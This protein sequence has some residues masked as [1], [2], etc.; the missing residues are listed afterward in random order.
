M[1]WERV[2]YPVS[3]GPHTFKWTYAKN[4]QN[5]AGLDAASIDQIVWPVADCAD[6]VIYVD[7]NATGEND[8]SSWADAYTEL[9][10]ALAQTLGG[11]DIWVANGTY[12]PDYDVMAQIHNGQREATF[13]LPNNIGIYGGF[14]GG[15]STIYSGGETARDQRDPQANETILTGDLW[16]DGD[17]N[18][19]SYHVVSARGVSPTSILDGFTITAGNAVNAP[20]PNYGGGGIFNEQNSRAN[21]TR[22]T[23]S[24]NLGG[25]RGG[26]ILND[27]SSPT[28]TDCVF[29]NNYADY[30]GAICNR[31][32]GSPSLTSS[33]K[34]NNC[35]F[36]DNTAMRGGA[37]FNEQNNSISMTGCL[38]LRN[39]VND[40]GGA[41]YNNGSATLTNCALVQNS[42]RYE[43]GGIYNEF[44][45]TLINSAVVGN[46]CDNAGAGLRPGSAGSQDIII[47][48]SIFWGNISFNQSDVEAAQIEHPSLSINHS[49]V[50]GWS[51]NFGGVGNI[52]DDPRF[53]AMTPTDLRLQLNSPCIDAGDNTVLTSDMTTDILGLA[54]RMDDPDTADTGNG[55]APLVDMG[56]HEYD[57]NGDYDGDLVLNQ[58]DNCPVTDN[59]DQADTDADDVGNVC[60]NCPDSGNPEQEDTDGDTWGDSCD[61]C[62]ELSSYVWSAQTNSEPP[63]R[64]GATTAYD[65]ARGVTVLFGGYKS[66]DW[67]N[68]TWESDGTGWTLR[69]PANIPS[70]RSNHAMV[71]DSAR[72]VVVLFGGK[73]A[74]GQSN[75][76]WEWDGTDW[77]LRTASVKPEARGFHAM[78]YDSAR[79]V[80]VL[81]GGMSGSSLNDTWEWDGTFWQQRT[82]AMLPSA[83][84]GHAMVYD[85]KHGV[86]VLF[87][88]PD[89][90]TWKWNGNN[91]IL[92]N[93]PFAPS[94]RIRHAMAY[95]QIRGTT[96]LFGGST[97]PQETWEWDGWNW[98][99]LDLSPTPPAGAPMAL[100]TMTYDIQNRMAVLFLTVNKLSTSSETWHYAINQDDADSDDIG[101]LCD[102][103]INDPNPD[104]ADEDGDGVGDECD[105]C[106]GTIPGFGVDADGCP[107][108]ITGDFNRDGDVDSG[109]FAQFQ[110]YATGPGLACDGDACTADFDADT[111]IDQD[112]FAIFQRCY[113]G[114]NIP[115]N[116]ADPACAN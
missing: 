85:R 107:A 3:A 37:I 62:P 94:A 1:D 33:P 6:P 34:L 87:G 115:V 35:Q 110:S 11:I 101:D 92:A 47:S 95:D 14:A 67:Y 30:G 76:T 58:Q 89:N 26:A 42:G 4:T 54:R 103:C 64:I 109:D 80:T 17:T 39:T 29:S 27:S 106:P 32:E 19:N 98:N 93:T 45:L 59:F 65:S 99:Q 60:D 20:Y 8:G 43:G 81:F 91:W 5:A 86:T 83:R 28:F 40:Q 36:L 96:L 48:N 25:H 82:S 61:L 72:G 78:A 18:N 57:P 15:D 24:T 73:T 112:D 70:P 51:G 114:E 9:Q 79:G 102:N 16:L 116:P 66:P 105:L 49:C 84:Y 46:T 41:L 55:T 50:Q 90:Q 68:D 71:Y 56:P 75:E 44:A 2:S 100:T 52:G 113:S 74:S 10:S 97:G 21:I 88:G 63:P 111:D 7:A 104:Q 31:S 13:Q 69:T 108:A 38:F 77:T 22:C 53:A 12:R 23:F